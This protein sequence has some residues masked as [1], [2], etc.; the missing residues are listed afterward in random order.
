MRPLDEFEIEERKRAFSRLYTDRWQGEVCL[1]PP[2]HQGRIHDM[3][4][5]AFYAG[6][7]HHR[8]QQEPVQTGGAD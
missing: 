4:K 3:L 1:M 8:R 2:H 6:Y 7:N 5:R